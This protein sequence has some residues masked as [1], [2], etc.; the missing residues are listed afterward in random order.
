MK[1]KRCKEVFNC[2]LCNAVDIQNHLILFKHSKEEKHICRECV[3]I[4]YL[5]ELENRT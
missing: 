1:E 4:I 3:Q 2:D 5:V